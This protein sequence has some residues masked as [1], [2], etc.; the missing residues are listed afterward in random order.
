MNTSFAE[1]L[2]ALSDSPMLQGTLAAFCTFILE[3]PT[4]LACA[5]LVADGRMLY[6]TALIGLALGIGLGDWGLYAL[7]RIVG[8]R[9]V[10]WGIVSRG[11]LE[12]VA[13]WF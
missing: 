10:T 4:T 6:A 11:R 7:G 2:R 5:L 3:D 13:L 12:R 8:E 1:A 9:I